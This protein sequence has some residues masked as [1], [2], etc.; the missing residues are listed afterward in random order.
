MSVLATTSIGG[1]VDG[2]GLASI[3][4]LINSA[5]INGY[6]EPSYTQIFSATPGSEGWSAL[7]P[8]NAVGQPV[9]LVLTLNLNN[10]RSIN[11]H[12]QTVLSASASD[13]DFAPTDIPSGTVV[14]GK[15]AAN[16][17]D[18]FLFV[19]TTS[20]YFSLQ[21]GSSNTSINI[22]VHD[23]L[24]GNFIAGSGSYS[25]T[26]I[27]AP[28][29]SGN[30]YIVRVNLNGYSFYDYQFYADVALPATLGGTV[31]FSGLTSWS[32]AFAEVLVFAPSFD[33]AYDI[34]GTGMV[35]LSDGTWSISDPPL[36]QVF[37][38]LSALS[39]G[40]EG[41]LKTQTI[42][43]SGGNYAIDFSPENSDKNVATGTWH[44]RTTT[45]GPLGEWLL[46][47]PSTSGEYVLD[48]ERTDDSWDPYMHLYDGLAGVEIERND[49]GGGNLNPRIQ[50][51]DFTAGY[52]YLIR[53]RALGS[54]YGDFRFKAEE[55]VTP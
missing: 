9:R 23:G 27:T 38:A 6:L 45:G 25:S 43:V 24:T 48:A 21:A 39:T 15:T 41:V 51:S 32:T 36:G 53:V 20:G 13:L 26:A 1:I 2:S 12:I 50:R 7:V 35:S 44:I 30:P 5:T 47:I 29:I 31:N 11:S 42:N 52:P 49:D 22:E 3:I 16:G 4:S 34:M 10:G 8:S 33:N 55:V 46:W 18:S 17:Y 40:G 19:P 54:G 37:I 28:L 14:N